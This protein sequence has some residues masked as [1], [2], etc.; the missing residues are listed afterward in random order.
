MFTNPVRRTSFAFLSILASGLH[1]SASLRAD[2]KLDFFENN[3]RPLLVQKCAECHSGSTPEGSLLV[4][5]IAALATGGTSGPAVV[6]GKPAE[7]LLL[8]R[9]VT[10]DEDLLMPPEDRLSE[11]EV[12][13]LKKWIEDGAVWP[14]SERGEW[15]T[16]EDRAR[17]WA[18][19]PVQNVKPPEVANGDWCQSPI[20]FFIAA[21]HADNNLTA[22]A[23][24]DRRTLIRRATLDLTGLP[25]TPEEVAVFVAD[26]SGDAF[27]QLV[28]RLLSSP[29]YGERW[30]RHWLD[31]ARYADTS[32]DGTDMP[33][34]EARYY[35]DYVIRAFNDD[36]PYDDFIVEQIA[37][38][39]QA[40]QDPDHARHNERII[41]TG[42]I[43]LSRRFGNSKFADMNLIV[44][45]TIDTLGKSM[46]GLTL[47]CARCHHHKFDPVTVNDYYGLYGY[48]ENTEYPHAGTEHQKERSGMVALCED[49]RLP[50]PY[51][52]A[53][54][55]A[56]TDKEKIV[57]D[58][59]AHIGGDPRTRGE[60]ARRAFLSVMSTE[61]PDIPQ[62]SSGRLH[63]AQWI[64]SADNSLTTRVIVNRVWQYHFGRGIVSSSS[65]FG[66]Q[67]SKPTHPELLDWLAGDFVRQGWS[68]KQL[69]RRI[70]LSAAYQL[71]STP[72]DQNLQQDQSNTWLW[73]FDRRRMDAETI[74]DNLLAVSGLLE[75]GDNGRHP[76]GPTEKL[77]YSQGRPF[78][79][80]FDHNHRSVYLMTARLN[81][82]PF[83]ALFDGPD[84]NKTTAARRE[85]TV[86]SQA[87]FMMNSDFMQKAAAA[88]AE[89]MV[90]FASNQQQRLDRAYMLAFGRAPSDEE[91][92]EATQF[93]VDYHQQL[94]ESGKA[95]KDAELLAWT[96]FARVTLSSSEFLYVD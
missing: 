51:E 22:V 88:F 26:E 71:S 81:K 60:T 77:R 21:K 94:I 91:S 96:A 36:L 12:S 78:N 34:P 27:A 52:S 14:N 74:R 6:P 20:D 59:K 30:G 24:A 18:F 11:Q 66:L 7:S 16:V 85:S 92:V 72:H 42:Y 3:V 73:R 76:F 69:H 32:G 55:W 50:E 86:A 10:D 35:R 63:L 23:P 43:A 44:D 19:Q 80:V 68:L 57:G 93:I 47:G 41:A 39:I 9:L 8:E 13:V 1:L 83:L 45:D 54:A 31:L 64:A 53:V 89:Q 46:L 38:D 28:D 33:V 82:H 79:K 70:M 15:E 61:V 90:T 2:D 62:D 84:P 40:K 4:D 49:D 67:G 25:P 56:V 58:I 87:L 37:G 17:H 29:A 65:N 5:D 48:F 95:D 75:E